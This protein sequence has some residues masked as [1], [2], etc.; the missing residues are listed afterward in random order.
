MPNT[1]SAARR[2]RSSAR[3][4][5]RNSQA[6][7][8]LK[9]LEKKY[10][11]LVAGGNNAESATALRSAVSAYDKAAKSG[12]IRRGTADRKK[13]RLSLRLK[14]AAAAPAETPK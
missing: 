1:K 2:A 14:K 8:R 7:S 13:S 4:H 9:T 12:I 11:T 5:A 10:L 6:K 3:K